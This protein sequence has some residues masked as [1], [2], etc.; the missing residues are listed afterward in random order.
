MCQNQQKSSSDSDETTPPL[1]TLT[2]RNSN[3]DIASTSSCVQPIR[4]SHGISRGT[5]KIRGRSGGNRGRRL[6]HDKDTQGG[7]SESVE[8]IGSDDTIWKILDPNQTFA[9]F[10]P[11]NETTEDSSIEENFVDWA[12]NL[13]SSLTSTLDLQYYVDIDYNLA[14][15][16]DISDAEVVS[17]IMGRET[18]MNENV[19]NSD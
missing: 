15:I 13:N 3:T 14:V 12:I 5:S 16:T 8:E 6:E 10:V 1:S 2:R 17:E 18:I 11:L 9:E 7:E 19:D 4:S